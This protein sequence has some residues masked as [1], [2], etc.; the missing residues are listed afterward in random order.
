MP[1]TE[2]PLEADFSF[3]VKDETVVVGHDRYKVVSQKDLLAISEKIDGATGIVLDS[4]LP[5]W[6]LRAYYKQC[7]DRE[8]SIPV[9]MFYPAISNLSDE[10]RVGAVLAEGLLD[11][12]LI[13][14]V[15]G[16]TSLT[17]ILFLLQAARARILTT[18]YITCPSCARTLY[19]IESTVNLIKKRT[20]HLKGVKIGVMGC[21]VNGP[22]EMA[23]ADFG[24]VGSGKGK[25]DLYFGQERIERGIEEKDAVEKLV[26]LIKKKGRWR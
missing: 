17:R 19:D 16:S 2:I 24:Y 18:D 22:G 12:L 15:I 10:A 25:I 8:D 13:P 4:R 6:K 21:I 5:L 11:F 9:G 7:S 20:Q 26:E 1:K 14:E 3:K 23:D